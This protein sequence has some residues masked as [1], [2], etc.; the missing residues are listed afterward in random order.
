MEQDGQKCPVN[1]GVSRVGQEYRAD[2]K[3]R[4]AMADNEE[5]AGDKPETQTDGEVAPPL[6]SSSKGQ[7]LSQF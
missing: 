2:L 1:C 7:S 5:T 4:S 6:V 3:E